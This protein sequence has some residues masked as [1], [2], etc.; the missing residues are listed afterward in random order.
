LT[1]PEGYYR[2]QLERNNMDKETKEITKAY[3]AAHQLNRI[4]SAIEEIL[5]LVKKDMEPREK[6]N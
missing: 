4:A 3:D 1:G 5:R 6:K 2:I